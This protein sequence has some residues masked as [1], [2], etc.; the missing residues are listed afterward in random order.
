MKKAM[1]WIVCV[2]GGLILIGA[3]INSGGDGTPPQTAAET[4]SEERAGELQA[5]M[6]EYTSSVAAADCRTLL[7][8]DLDA[9][10]HLPEVLA[11]SDPIVRVGS[12]IDADFD[13]SFGK[14]SQ[15]EWVSQAVAWS[16]ARPGGCD[17]LFDLYNLAEVVSTAE[18]R[19]LSAW[20]TCSGGG[21]RD[22]GLTDE[23]MF[24]VA[25][26]SRLPEAVVDGLVPLGH[27]IC[28]VLDVDSSA[29]AFNAVGNTMIVDIPAL[30]ETDI[31]W[32][33]G[34][35]V[36]ALCPEHQP[37]MTAWIES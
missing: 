22:A 34:A 37:A 23:E 26:A 28:D 9:I 24:V 21:V 35:A 14:C 10:E 5:E 30:K 27:A 20:E 12:I 19:L 29:A 32:V 36:A 18:K 25:V 16:A 4:I 11:D 31:G 3:A 1:I 17:L 13:V 6:A 7:F 2:V 33:L 15:V 8:E